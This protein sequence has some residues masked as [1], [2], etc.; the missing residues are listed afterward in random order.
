MTM[1]PIFKVAIVAGDYLL[2]ALMALA[3]V[4]LREAAA[5]ESGAR[6]S[7]GM[8]AFGDFMLFGA[9][10]GVVALLPTGMGLSFLLSR[11]RVPP[12]STDPTAASGTLPAGQES[13]LPER[14]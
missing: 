11:R 5:G 1:K 8:S 6:A 10:F 4:A 7:D 9:V 12:R 2:A 14:R 13:R 3:A